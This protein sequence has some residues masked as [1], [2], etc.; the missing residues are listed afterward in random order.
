MDISPRAID[1]LSVVDLVL[2]E[3]TRITRRLFKKYDISNKLKVIND[4]NENYKKDNIINYLLEGKDLA[5]VSDAGTPCISDPGYRIVNGAR[6]NKIKVVTIPGPCSVIAALSISGL[7]T[8][9][10]YYQGFLPKKKGRQTK[11]KELVEFDCSIVLFE[12]PKRIIKTLNDILL[13]LGDRTVALCREL[14][15]IYEEVK[16]DKVSLLIEESKSIKQKGEY[17]IIIAK[18]GYKY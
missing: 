9:N 5:F 8:D 13:Y 16:V 17:V 3:D 6:K 14:T 15:K 11:F 12:S 7:P 1:T 2:C 4:I 18:E 10:F